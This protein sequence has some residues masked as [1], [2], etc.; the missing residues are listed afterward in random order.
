MDVQ[1]WVWVATVGAIVIMLAIDFFGHARKPHAPTLKE[2]GLWS[3]GYVLIALLFGLFVLW[4]WGGD[5]AIQYYSGYVTEKSLSVDNLFVFVLIFTSFRVPREY[6]Q[7]VLLIGIIIAL[8][9]RTAFIFVGAAMVANL[10]WIFYIFGA[11]LL[12]TAVTQLKSNDD[13]EDSKEPGAV[14]VVRRIFPTTD[15]YHGDKLLHKHEGRWHVTPMMVVIVAI[16][17][18]D[19]LFAVDSIPAIFG[20]TQEPFLVFAANAFSLLGLLQLYFLIDGLLD[21]LIYLNYGLAA[22]LGFIGAKLVIHALHTNELSFINGG[23]P[24]L[25]IPEPSTWVSLGVIVGI[26]TVT[27]VASLLVGRNKADAPEASEASEADRIEN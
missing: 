4:E 25:A 23:E 8:A 6:Q 9:L 24:W 18:A 13:E 19:V 20:L 1:P 7:K 5:F 15:G 17:A 27:T 11:F 16:G 3:L 21:R 26:L 12:Y 14:R 22:I 2:A 10:S